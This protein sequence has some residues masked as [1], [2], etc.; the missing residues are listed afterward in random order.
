MAVAPSDTRTMP[1]HC[2]SSFHTA[3]VVSHRCHVPTICLLYA[4]F[5][6]RRHKEKETF[7]PQISPVLPENLTCSPSSLFKQTNRNYSF[8]YAIS[9]NCEKMTISLVTYVSF[10]GCPNARNNSAPTGRIF[11]KFYISVFFKN[12][13]KIEVY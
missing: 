13:L 10:S 3:A 6:V 8:F 9:Q 7:R 1:A 11:V 5:S 2:G 12:L 4:K